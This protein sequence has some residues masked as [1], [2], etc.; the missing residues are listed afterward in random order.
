M[1]LEDKN[2]RRLMKGSKLE[3]PFS[4]F[5]DKMM[6]KVK[7]FDENNQ[8]AYRYKMLGLIFFLLGTVF[9]IGLNFIFTQ[10]IH[11]LSSST[12]IQERF[13]LISQIIY[14]VLIVI[15]S[16]KIWKLLKIKQNFRM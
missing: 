8:K 13:Y 2:I 1:E 16:D 3:L 11:Y 14:V 5:E 10:N 15:F 6:M 4:G 12:V 9:G 7:A